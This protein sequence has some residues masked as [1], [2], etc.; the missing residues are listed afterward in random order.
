[1]GVFDYLLSFKPEI[2]STLWKGG[3][4]QARWDIPLVWSGNFDDGQPL[5]GSRNDPRMDRAMLFQGINIAPGLMAN[6]GA[7]LVLHNIYG[8]MNELTWS[9]GGGAHRLRATQAWGRDSE[10]RRTLDVYLG[11][12]RYLYAPLDLSIEATAGRFLWQDR[13]FSLELKRFFADTAVST[14]YK[15]TKTLEGKHWQ[16]AGIQ[17]VFPLTPRKDL[18]IGPLQ[19]RG[20]DEWAYAQETT[21]AIGGQKTNDVLTQALAINPQPTPALYHSYYNRDRLSADYVLQHLDRLREAW[22]LYR[23]ELFDSK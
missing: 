9:P 12:Y 15:N 5:R 6:I 23:N 2:L 11:S 3:V 21:L 13:G 20:T 4:F 17:F 8:T 19:V 18:K 14:Y 16:A 22:R 10:T 7:G 1:V